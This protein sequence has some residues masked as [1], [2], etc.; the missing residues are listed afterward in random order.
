MG[1][2]STVPSEP[3]ANRMGI[4]VNAALEAEEGAAMATIRKRTL[5]SGKVVWQAD[6][7][8]A[9]GSRRHKQFPT[10]KEADG[11]LTRARSEV[12]TGVHVPDSISVTVAQAAQ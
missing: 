1:S 7:V 6:Y 9:G 4:S 12:A 5:P 2:R 3:I 10:K 8:D 11:F